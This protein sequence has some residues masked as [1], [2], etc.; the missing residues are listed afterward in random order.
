MKEIRNPNHPKKGSTMKVDPI[1][2]VKDVK[3]MSKALKDNPR[4]R[5]L[6]VGVF[7]RREFLIRSRA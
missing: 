6:F 3:S 4:D 7:E 2:S 5:L 1:R